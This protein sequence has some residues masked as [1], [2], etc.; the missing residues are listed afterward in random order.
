VRQSVHRVGVLG[1]RLGVR[2]GLVVAVAQLVVNRPEKL[3]LRPPQLRKLLRRPDLYKIT[4]SVF[5]PACARKPWE[6]R[7]CGNLNCQQV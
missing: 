2:G 3:A 4:S 7:T 5:T 1:H 6:Y